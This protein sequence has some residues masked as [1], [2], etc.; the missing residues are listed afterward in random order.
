MVDNFPKNVK[1]SLFVA[2]GLNSKLGNEICRILLLLWREFLISVS[3][4]VKI[5]Y[6][7]LRT[8]IGKQVKVSDKLTTPLQVLKYLKN[9]IKENTI[10]KEDI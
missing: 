5:E 3:M 10:K 9:I 7:I 1:L 6:F 2:K 4:E 8:K